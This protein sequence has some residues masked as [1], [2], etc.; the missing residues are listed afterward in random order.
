MKAERASQ[1]NLLQ[2][3]DYMAAV[4]GRY[5][6]GQDRAEVYRNLIVNREAGLRRL[7]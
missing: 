6:A 1:N 4:T 3:A 5:V 7:P 2:L